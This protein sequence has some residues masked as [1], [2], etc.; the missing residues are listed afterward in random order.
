MSFAEYIAARGLSPARFV[1]GD[2]GALIVDHVLKYETLHAELDNLFAQMGVTERLP[3]AGDRNKSKK[4]PRDSYLIADV[5]KILNPKIT[6]DCDV[7]GYE[8]ID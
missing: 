2:S 8:I 6:Q 7:L 4:Q 5:L 3:R 1:C